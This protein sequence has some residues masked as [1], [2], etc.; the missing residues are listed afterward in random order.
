M[1]P[2]TVL[3]T[4]RKGRIK[5]NILGECLEKEKEDLVPSINRLLSLDRL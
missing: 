4:E 1:V 2:S 5:H 3:V